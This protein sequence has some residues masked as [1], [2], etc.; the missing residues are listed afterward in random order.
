MSSR[1]MMSG[2]EPP[3]GGKG[4]VLLEVGCWTV[5]H[6]PT[7]RHYYFTTF[8]Y[9]VVVFKVSSQLLDSCLHQIHGVPVRD[10]HSHG[11][12]GIGQPVDVV[13]L[14]GDPLLAFQP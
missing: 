13:H 12:P 4:A 11:R 6:I 3:A 5:S 9:E 14:E 7:F 2:K 8:D 1:Q 10:S